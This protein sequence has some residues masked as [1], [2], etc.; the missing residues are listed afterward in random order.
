MGPQVVAFA[1]INQLRASG[2]WIIE[3]SGEMLHIDPGPGALVRAKEYK[4]DL[5]KLTGLLVSHAHPDHYGDAEMVLEAMTGGAKVKR[6]VLIG[7]ENVI[8][9]GKTYHPVF[10][11]YHLKAVDK[12]VVMKA[13]DKTNIGKINITATKTVHD[14]PKCIGFVFEGSKKI[15]FTSDGEYFKGQ[16]EYYKG[17]DYLVINCMIQ[18][19]YSWPGHINVN[20]AA[21]LIKEVNPKTAILKD[22]SSYLLEAGPEEQIEWIEKTT[23]I[24]TIAAKD[25]MK[26]NL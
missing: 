22:F 19:D 10:S 25:G 23:G 20:D 2:G 7:N 24:K 11:P 5:F 26:L 6:G 4:V 21:K 13:G 14:E 9:G 12:Y 18:K 17:C 8:K 1:V 16:A 15:G 3:M